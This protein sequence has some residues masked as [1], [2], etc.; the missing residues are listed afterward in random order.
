[1]GSCEPMSIFGK[2]CRDYVGFLSTGLVLIVV[3][4]LVRFVAGVSGLPYDRATNLTSVT[5]LVF[6]L[7]IIYG[8][9]AAALRFGGYRHL[10]PLALLLSFTMYG[11]IVLAITVEGVSGIR[12]YFHSPGSGYAPHGMGLLEHVIGQLSVMGTMTVAILGTAILGYLLSRH[13]AYL[14]NA[15][16]LLAAMA[17]L[18]FVAGTVGV[19]YAVGSWIT[20]LSLLSLLLA[21]Y[22]GYRASSQGFDGYLHMLLIGFIIAFATTHLVAYGIV[23]TDG[24]GI[25]SYYHAPGSLQSQGAGVRQNIEAHLKFSPVLILALTAAASTAFALGRRKAHPPNLQSA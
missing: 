17:V 5:I 21:A 16:L 12:G 19:P 1:M 14:R 18:R 15:F 6:L 24:L 8:Q 10:L 13:L 11:F 3:M 25:S 7:A 9:R 4:G 23:V 20:S 2:S 22:Y